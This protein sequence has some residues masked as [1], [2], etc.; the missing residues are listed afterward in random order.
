M[1]WLWR[2]ALLQVGIFAEEA[3]LG[4]MFGWRVEFLASGKCLGGGFHYEAGILRRGAFWVELAWLWLLVV[5]WR[6]EL[7]TEGAELAGFVSVD[8]ICV[9]WWRQ[10]LEKIIGHGVFI[11][12]CSLARLFGMMHYHFCLICNNIEH[13]NINASHRQRGKGNVGDWKKH[14]ANTAMVLAKV[15]PIASGL[16]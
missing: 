9:G 2:L 16:V 1:A 12:S 7:L 6:E 14:Q 15:A 5:L 8:W 11:A 3:G 13:G 4:G 10:W